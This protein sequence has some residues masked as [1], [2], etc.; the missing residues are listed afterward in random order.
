MGLQ[1]FIVYDGWWR[2]VKEKYK[3]A[4]CQM[5]SQDDKQKNLMQAAEMIAEN[6]K[7]GASIIVFPE[8]MNYM[9]DGYRRQA[10][11]VPGET[12][13]F[14]C[15]KAKEHGVW[16]LSGSFPEKTETSCP[17]NTMA[18]LSPDGGIFCKYSKLH[19]FDIELENGK[20]YKESASNTC[21]DEIV[22]AKT[23]LGCFGFAICY[24][25]R[26]GELFRL[27]A[28]NGAQVI[29]VPSS[30]TAETGKAHWE[31]LLR[32]RAIENGVY[33]VAAD[34]TG[35]KSTMEAYG[36]SMV[37]DPWGNVLAEAGTGVCSIM[38]EI[39]PAMVE[40]VRRQIPSLENRRTDMYRIESARLAVYGL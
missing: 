29:F 38:A 10:E 16:V 31:P 5:D 14:L 26:F 18:L 8:T 24:D 3:V 12:T 15:R 9:G 36:H 23:E 28:L 32:A 33:I 21:G 20:S 19:M 4:V 37:V 2:L 17:K 34:Q 39:H 30:F 7:N 40:S 6:A 11:T 25:L 1:A 27:M 35:E 13:D 22:L